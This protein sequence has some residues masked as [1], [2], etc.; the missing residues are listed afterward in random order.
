MPPIQCRSLRSE[1]VYLGNLGRR[2]VYAPDVGGEGGAVVICAIAA[3][4]MMVGSTLSTFLDARFLA[5]AW[6]FLFTA[7]TP[8]LLL[9]TTWLLLF[10]LAAADFSAVLLLLFAE[11]VVTTGGGDTEG[12]DQLKILPA[13]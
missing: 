10:L 7:E 5:F 1:R 3:T 12:E 6:F 4:S 11:S 8:P 9:V 2:R 13:R